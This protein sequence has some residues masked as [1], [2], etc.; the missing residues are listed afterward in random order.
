MMASFRITRRQV[1]VVLA[2]VTIAVLAPLGGGAAGPESLTPVIVELFTSEGCSSCPPADALLRTLE[3][4]QPVAGV[5]IIPLGE[6]VDY[7]NRLGWPDPFSSPLFTTRQQAYAKALNAR[8]VYTPQMVVDGQ[9]EFVGSRPVTAREEILRARR[10]PKAPLIL[11]A[12][13]SPGSRVLTVH[14][15]IGPAPHASADDQTEVWFAV[16]ESGLTTDVKAGENMFRRLHHTGVVRHLERIDALR[17]PAAPSHHVEARL[18]LD[19]E[20]NRDQL[21]AVVFLQERDSL[22]IVGAAQAGVAVPD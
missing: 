7:W 17:D 10:A 22:R 18:R 3:R 2:A 19:P 20:W 9:A 8:S 15:E 5:L 4:N 1:L 16:T 14:A 12:A 21:R 6:H 11:D 13:V